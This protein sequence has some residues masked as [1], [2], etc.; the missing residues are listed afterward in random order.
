[1]LR[2]DKEDIDSGVGLTQA[3]LKSIIQD[4]VRLCGIYLKVKSFLLTKGIKC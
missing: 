3:R 1:M 2:K 4:L